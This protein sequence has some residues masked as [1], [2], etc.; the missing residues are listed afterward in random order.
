LFDNEI[1]M[2][3]LKGLIAAAYTPFDTEGSLNAGLIPGYAGYLKKLGVNG[4][5][6][7]GTTGEGA[8][9]TGKE[10]MLAAETWVKQKDPEFKVIIHVGHNSL[11]MA[12]ELAKQAQ[13]IG[14]DGIGAMAPYFFKPQNI[15]DLVSFNAA[16]AKEAPDLPFFYYH[17]PAM[18]G[19]NFP[20]VAFLKAAEKKIT[21]LAGI[22]YT[23]DDFMDMK[24]CLDHANKKYTILQ[25]H[26]EMLLSGLVLGVKAAIGST[27]NYMTPIYLELIEAFNGSDLERANE[28]QLKV[29]KIVQVLIKYGGGVKAGKSIM[30]LVGLDCGLPRLPVQSLSLAEQ[31]QLQKELEVLDFHDYA[32]DF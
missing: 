32:V 20:M 26:D 7:N 29:M 6:V 5:F 21:N 8:S 16:I 11:R 3:K 31:D 27:Y 15:D 10:R 23:H 24:L 12:Q 18:S 19:V 22:K 1:E 30:G 2:H 28:L 14:A 17:L 9:L 13:Q 4:V 25:G